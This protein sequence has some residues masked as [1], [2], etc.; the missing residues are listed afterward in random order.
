MMDSN[1]NSAEG[2]A[3]WGM[4]SDLPGNPLMWIFILSELLV[5]GGFFAAYGFARIGEREVFDASQALLDPL[6]G[7]LNTMVL[8]T[9]GLC[10][11]LAMEARAAG[12]VARC[13]GWLIGAMS[14]GTVFCVIKLAEFVQ[15]F[16]AGLTPDTNTFFTYYYLL[17]GFHF[18]HVVYGLLILAL[19]AWRASEANVETGV[20]FWHMVDLIWIILYPLIYLLR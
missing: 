2:E 12:S 19:V 9:S 13:R 1:K 17:T 18:A 11:A 3:H 7:G 15:K 6:V 8:L 4:L 20:A 14:L 10:A 5:F 16:S